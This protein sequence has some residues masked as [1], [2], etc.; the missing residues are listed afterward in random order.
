MASSPNNMTAC[1]CGMRGEGEKT[2]TSFQVFSTQKVTDQNGTTHHSNL[3]WDRKKN[4]ADGI[5]LE[6]GRKVREN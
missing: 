5:C 4:Q 3:W 6:T 2:S 1:P